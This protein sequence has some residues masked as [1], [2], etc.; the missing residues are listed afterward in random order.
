MRFQPRIKLRA[1]MILIAIAG[2][3]LGLHRR[4]RRLDRLSLVYSTQASNLENTLIGPDGTTRTAPQTDD[5]VD[6]IL[7]RVHWNDSVAFEYR[8]AATRPWL[9]FDPDPRSIVCACG[10]H[11]THKPRTLN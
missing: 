4:S 1:L 7:D 11:L 10:Y 5:Q 6:A 3:A 9:P 2:L 8:K